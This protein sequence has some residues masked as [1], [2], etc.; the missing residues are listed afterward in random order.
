[1]IRY[2]ASGVSYTSYSFTMFGWCR[3]AKMSTS[4]MSR[5]RFSGAN[6]VIRIVFIANLPP[7]ALSVSTLAQ[8]SLV[9]YSA[10]RSRRSD[11]ELLRGKHIDSL[12]IPTRSSPQSKGYSFL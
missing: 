8:S 3:R 9:H 4:W 12:D 1:M 6:P 7:V 10:D 2:I 11:T 5:S